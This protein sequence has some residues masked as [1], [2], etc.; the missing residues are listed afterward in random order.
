MTNY[1][2]KFLSLFT[3]KSIKNKETIHTIFLFLYRKNKLRIDIIV[4]EKG[5]LYMLFVIYIR[6]DLKKKCRPNCDSK[7]Q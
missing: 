4:K 7:K 6:K 5:V 2:R 3:T 1:K